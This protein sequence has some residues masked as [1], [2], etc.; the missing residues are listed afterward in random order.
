M[1]ENFTSWILRSWTMSALRYSNTKFWIPTHNKN[2]IRW[3]LSKNFWKTTIRK[4][5]F[6]FFLRKIIFTKKFKIWKQFLNDYWS[7][8]FFFLNQ[9]KLKWQFSSCQHFFS[10][11]KNRDILLFSKQTTFHQKFKK[12][13]STEVLIWS[14]ELQIC[15]ECQKICFQHIHF[16]F[17]KH[18]KSES[19]FHLK[20]HFF[21][22]FSYVIVKQWWHKVIEVV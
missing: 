9:H 4:R 10:K 2:D 8:L 18:F 20:R 7:Q 13:D 6:P 11:V 22:S 1:F 14:Q 17:S 19:F 3:F 21:F 15:Q 5:F 12:K 16:I